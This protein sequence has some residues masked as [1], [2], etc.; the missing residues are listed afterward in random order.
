MRLKMGVNPIGV[1]PELIL[2]IMAADAIYQKRGYECVVTSLNEGNHSN[3]SRHYQ[4]MAVD[5]RT[6]DF[7][8]AVANEICNDLR[9]ALGPHYLVLNES[10]HIHIGYQPK[11]P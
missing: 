9:L 6:R 1:K 2:A 5:L 7:N 3:T 11:K 8:G 10:N 4:G